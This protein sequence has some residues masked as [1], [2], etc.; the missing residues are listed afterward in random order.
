[1]RLALLGHDLRRV[2]QQAA[3]NALMVLDRFL[4]QGMLHYERMTEEDK[5]KLRLRRVY[6]LAPD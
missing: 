1:M 6:F 5:A 3:N 2:R 4:D